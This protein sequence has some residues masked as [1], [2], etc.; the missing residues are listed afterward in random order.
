MDMGTPSLFDRDAAIAF[1][2]DAVGRQVSNHAFL[3]RDGSSVRLSDFRGLPLVISMIYTSCYHI[4]P[5][6][7]QH[8]DDVVKKARASLGDDAFNVITVGFDTIRDTPPMMDDFAR[9]QGVSDDRWSFLATDEST[10]RALA[11]EI[12]FLFEPATGGGFDHLIQT[13][14][15]D[16]EGRVY[17][18]VH[19]IAFETPVLIEP[20]KQ[21]V[22]GV[23]GEESLFESIGKQVRLFCTVYDPAADKYKFDYSLFIGMFIAVLCVGFVGINLV[24]EWR[25]TLGASS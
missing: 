24:K 13:T 1:S 25:K 7:T 21:L 4:C 2:R 20:L 17:R 5:T 15:L 12:G 19:G 3:S 8:L 14:V 23:T 22:L 10:A 6:T 16:G 11:N 9:Q 18:Q